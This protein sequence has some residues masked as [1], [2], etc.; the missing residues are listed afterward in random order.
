MA[1]AGGRSQSDT[2]SNAPASGHLIGRYDFSEPVIV[3]ASWPLRAVD[4]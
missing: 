1:D 4:D 2:L 3:G